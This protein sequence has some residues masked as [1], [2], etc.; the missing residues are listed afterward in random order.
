MVQAQELLGRI[1]E[2]PSS[3]APL[4][5]D[6]LGR[7]GETANPAKPGAAEEKISKLSLQQQVPNEGAEEDVSAF[8]SVEKILDCFQERRILSTY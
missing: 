3:Y 8:R 2:A 1:Q 4:E 5:L 6:H 7:I